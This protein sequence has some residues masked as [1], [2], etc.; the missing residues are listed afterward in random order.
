ME[1]VFIEKMDK[2]K[3]IGPSPLPVKN[4]P[5]QRLRSAPIVTDPN[6]TSW[7]DKTIIQPK[8]ILT[9][10]F[11]V[12]VFIATKIFGIDVDLGA[13]FD[14]ADGLQLGELILGVGTTVA[15]LLFDTNKNK[16]TLPADNG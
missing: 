9:I 14:M 4:K 11:T 10:V 2:A 15:A 7:K 16:P 13:L 8:P 5:K 6:K 12:A 3:P 1:P